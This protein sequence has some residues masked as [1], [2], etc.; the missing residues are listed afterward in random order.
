MTTKL[1]YEQTLETLEALLENFHRIRFASSLSAEDMVLAHIIGQHAMPISIFTL[2]TGRLNPETYDLLSNARKDQI[3]VIFPESPN[4]QA[5][6]R[7]YGINGFYNSI[8]ARKACCAAR[9]IA[10]LRRALLGSDAWVTGL[11]RDQSSAR[12]SLSHLE[13]DS[14]TNLPKCSPLLHWQDTDV[15]AYVDEHKIK[16]NQLYSKGFKSIGCAPCTRAVAAEEHPRAGRW[17]WESESQKECG[18]HVN[19]E[20]LLSRSY[21]PPY[22]KEAL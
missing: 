19:A 16:V 6:T 10:P 5:F 8:E 12:Q 18:L 22:E 2:D 7:T 20:G 14:G 21:E 3:E 1:I 9:K 15:W 4:V 17:W 11:R 13:I